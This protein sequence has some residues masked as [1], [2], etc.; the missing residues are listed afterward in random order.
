MKLGFVG[1]GR[2]GAS[3]ARNLLSAGHEVCV[4]N[5]TRDKAETLKSD[6]ARIADSP[7]EAAQGNEA[8]LSMLA[9]DAAVEGVTFGKQGIAAGLAPGAVHISQSTISVALGRKLAQEHA[10]HQQTYLSA[11]VFGRPDAAAAKRL[12][13]VAAGDPQAV[14]RFQPVF[15]AIG[16]QT[17]VAG[18]EAWQ[19]NALKVCGNFMIASMLETFG[20]AFAT[21]RKAGVEPHLFL[22]VMNELFGSPV[23]KG[24]GGAIAGGV[25][26]PAGFALKLGLKDVGLVLDA[27]KE[28]AVPMPFASV[29]RDQ[30]LSAIANGQGE[31]DWSSVALVAARNAGLPVLEKV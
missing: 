19:A 20:E 30:C 14:A 13:V 23:Y 18:P 12:I 17:F 1:L 4:Y 22:D 3:I 7:A 27:A 6:G 15:E 31:M 26:E 21:M 16:R 29:L 11:P 28:L 2:M 25:F 24:Y 10:Q 8:V 5:R 9:D